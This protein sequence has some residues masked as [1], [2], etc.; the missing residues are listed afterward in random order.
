MAFPAEGTVFDF[1][2]DEAT[3]TMAHWAQRVPAFTYT[4]DSFS[5]LFVPTVE[6]TRL[7][8]LLD[9]LLPNKHHVMFVGN[10]GGCRGAGGTECGV[11]RTAGCGEKASVVKSVAAPNHAC[12][13]PEMGLTRSPHQLL[14]ALTTFTYPGLPPQAP[15]RRRWCATSCAAWT[16]R[17]RWPTPST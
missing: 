9:L 17:P 12:Q 16:R 11:E 10:S 2:V 1:Y 15:A 14:R 4:P 6:T 5:S 8:Y 13:L 7:T 3:C